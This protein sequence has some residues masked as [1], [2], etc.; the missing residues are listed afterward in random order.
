MIAAGKDAEVA[1][2]LGVKPHAARDWRLRDSIP[3]ERWNDIVAAGFATLS[4]LADAASM[5]LAS[6][7][8]ETQGRAA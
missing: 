2:A 6:A 8:A 1:I 5:R 3:A 7:D 4:E